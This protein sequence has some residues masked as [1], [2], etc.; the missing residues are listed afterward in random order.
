MASQDVRGGADTARS[1]DGTFRVLECKRLFDVIF[2]LMIAPLVLPVIGILW[3]LVRLCDDRSSG[4]FGHVRVGQGGKSFRCFKIRSMVPHAEE[5][6]AEYLERNEEAREEWEQNAKLK[7][8][9]RVT[10]L[11]RFLRKSSL[12]ELPQLLNV[13]RGEM[14]FV[15]PRPVPK[16]ELAERYGEKRWVYEATKPGITGLWQ[17]SGRNDVSYSERIALDER[18]LAHRNFALDLK[19]ILKTALVVISRTGQ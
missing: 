12:D 8:D 10:K 17:V 18:Y 13:L 14:S 2:A 4:F 1:V 3:F 9:P 11:G 19:I 7:V 5:R 15:G 16:Q 6:L